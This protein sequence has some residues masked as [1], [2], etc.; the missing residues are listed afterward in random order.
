MRLVD[1][2]SVYQSFEQA[3][4]ADFAWV[5][6]NL[7]SATKSALI[8]NK[9]AALET[10][11][12]LIQF[13]K[14]TVRTTWSMVAEAKRQPHNRWTKRTETVELSER[15]K[16]RL[17]FLDNAVG[18]AVERMLFPSRLASTAPIA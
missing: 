15:E 12:G 4:G 9:Q 8:R 3:R 18:L 10:G 5:I 1:L 17:Q 14:P 6:V 7:G 2:R 13:E 11:V 16:G